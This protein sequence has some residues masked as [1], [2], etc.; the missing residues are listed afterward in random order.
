[1][2]TFIA[3]GLYA[4]IFGWFFILVAFLLIDKDYSDSVLI[5]GIAV[6]SYGLIS[7]TVFLLNDD[8]WKT[9]EEIK[10]ER[11]EYSKKLETVAALKVILVE[12]AVKKLGWTSKYVQEKVELKL[13]ENNDTQ[14]STT[15]AK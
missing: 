14:K 4:L 2:R 9:A 10:K 15:S 11:A 5:V 1:M 7:S 12:E 6:A 3:I 13:K 8:I